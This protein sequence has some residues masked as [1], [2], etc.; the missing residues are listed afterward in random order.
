MDGKTSYPLRVTR[1][2]LLI[3]V[4]AHIF[5]HGRV[6]GVSFRYYVLKRST[7]LGLR[8]YVRNLHDGRVEIL[9]QGSPEGV[10]KLV[11]YVRNSPG[12]S[13]VVK[14]DIN[15]EEPLNGLSSFRIEF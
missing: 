8:G 15:W 2:S 6:Q 12:L 3:M 4:Q 14:L 7:D 9:A 5:A 11:D 10:Q 13:Y 1:H